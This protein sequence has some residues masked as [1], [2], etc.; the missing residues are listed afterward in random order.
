MDNRERQIEMW[1]DVAAEVFAA[2]DRIGLKWFP[3]LRKAKEMTDGERRQLCEDYLRAI[4]TEIVSGIEM[5]D[6]DIVN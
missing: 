5:Y 1:M 6:E 2:E 3:E 4:A